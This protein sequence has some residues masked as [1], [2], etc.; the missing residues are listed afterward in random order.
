MDQITPNNPKYA[1]TVKTG[2]P[3]IPINADRSYNVP[4]R[5]G[6]AT[7]NIPIANITNGI[8]QLGIFQKPKIRNTRRAG[9][10]TIPT[11]DVKVFPLL[12]PYKVAALIKYVATT[13]NQK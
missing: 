3:T 2:A 5:E 1:R 11:M 4:G 9:K 7:I 6:I 10:L 12:F 13:K 8:H